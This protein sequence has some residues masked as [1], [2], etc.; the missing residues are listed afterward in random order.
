MQEK[1]LNSHPASNAIYAF[2]DAR[3]RSKE[4]EPTFPIT[5]QVIGDTIYEL[6]GKAYDYFDL[7]KT[8][9]KNFLAVK[10]SK[11][12][13]KDYEMKDKLEEFVTRNN[14]TMVRTNTGLI[15]RIPK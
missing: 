13:I 5:T 10:L 3:K 14:G 6:A 11:P 8:Y 4:N 1:E 2:L 12:S 9:R 7:Y 15:F